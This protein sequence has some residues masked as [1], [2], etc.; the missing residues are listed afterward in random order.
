MCNA[1]AA[2][3]KKEHP[4]AGVEMS[5][6]PH[7]LPHASIKS[8]KI[9]LFINCTCAP[10][11]YTCLCDADR[12]LI[13]VHD[14]DDNADDDTQVMV[15]NVDT[16]SNVLLAT[17]STGIRA[18]VEV[19][20]MTAWLHRSSLS[21]HVTNTDAQGILPLFRPLFMSEVNRVLADTSF[22]YPGSPRL[23]TWIEPEILIDDGRVQLAGDLEMDETALKRAIQ[24]RT[25]TQ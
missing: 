23:F 4:H 10:L 9:V 25:S 2:P 6:L 11:Q 16:E 20:N 22:N 18:Q 24:Q 19:A 3:I 8:G 13:S 21:V 15:I 12:V 5:I 17:T 7:G 1:I 14:D